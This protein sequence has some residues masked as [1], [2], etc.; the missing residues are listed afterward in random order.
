MSGLCVGVGTL[1]L[2]V[3]ALMFLHVGILLRHLYMFRLRSVN[4][5]SLRFLS[6]GLRSTT[7]RARLR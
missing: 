5:C 6:P 7:F 3:S 1:A 2:G 4:S